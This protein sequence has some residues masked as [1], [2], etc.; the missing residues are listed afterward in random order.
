MYGNTPFRIN[1]MQLSLLAFREK[2]QVNWETKSNFS[3]LTPDRLRRVIGTIE[4][5][6]IDI[7]G[8]QRLPKYGSKEVPLRIQYELT[9]AKDFGLQ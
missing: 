2:K 9:D 4:N 3:Q 7:N 6:H 1:K 5:Q 8:L